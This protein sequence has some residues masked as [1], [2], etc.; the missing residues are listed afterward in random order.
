MNKIGKYIYTVVV[1]SFA[2]LSVYY[3]GLSTLSIGDI[4]VLLGFVVLILLSLKNDVPLLGRCFFS[5]IPFLL[6]VFFRSFFAESSDV[7]FRSLRYLFYLSF[8]ALF[9]QTYFNLSMTMRVY[10]KICLFASVL[11]IIQYISYYL[12][13]FYI[14]GYVSFIP[15]MGDSMELYSEKM[16]E[17]ASLDSRM[18]SIFAEPAHYASY[19]CIFIAM[20]VFLKKK[21]NFVHF[22]CGIGVLV[23]SSSTGVSMI[24]F[25]LS[26]VIIEKS[27]SGFLL[28]KA[29]FKLIVFFILFILL[30]KTPF[31]QVIVERIEKG[32]SFDGRF[33]GYGVMM[34]NFVSLKDYFWGMG[35]I[36]L[37]YY[38]AGWARL[39][40][41][42]GFLGCFLYCF[43]IVKKINGSLKNFELLL[44][45]FFLG[46]G[47]LI[48]LS[49]GSMLMLS[50]LLN[51]EKRESVDEFKIN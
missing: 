51:M 45:Y 25:I 46:V 35:M 47:T 19:V 50:Y 39:F 33:G 20:S 21:V 31:Y 24:L 11:I 43:P 13:H 1:T 40:F 8:V 48:F 4:S 27:F 38:L 32:D 23:S 9:S 34:D 17:F 42:F 41:C 18:R 49:G 36:K 30:L 44:T 12:F 14:P 28:N 10:E 2:P 26:C 29:F 22:L 37:D 7:F 5:F 15:Q 6:F 16:L 3:S